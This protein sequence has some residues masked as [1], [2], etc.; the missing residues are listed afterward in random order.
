MTPEHGKAPEAGKEHAS[1]SPEAIPE[2]TIHA[3]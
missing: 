1:N 2:S 3:S